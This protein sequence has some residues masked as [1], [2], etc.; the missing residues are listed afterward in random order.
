MKKTMRQSEAQ[1]RAQWMT[2]FNDQVIS[3]APVHS[4][5]INWSD[6]LHFYF[7]G[8]TPA[9]SAARYLASRPNGPE[10]MTQ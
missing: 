7:T 1:R 5:R 10:G 3:L 4:G 2:E 8:L 6:A 9:E